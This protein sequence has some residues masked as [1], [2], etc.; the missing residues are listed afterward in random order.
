MSAF[1]VADKTINR[2]VSKMKFRMVH[3]H[4]KEEF[5]KLGLNPDQ[6]FFEH[7]I[8]KALFDMN[9]RAVNARY[10]Q[11]E[12]ETFRELNYKYK[13]E[14]TSAGIYQEYKSLR[15]LMYQCSE[16]DV[17]EE[18]LYKLMEKYGNELAY[19]IVT[20]SEKYEESDWG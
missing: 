10:G 14:F 7:R 18:A 13:D 9:V 4:L 19:E 6:P 17:P 12:A 8:G 20:S 15:C 16:G 11:G 5:I 2:V 3:S 1:V